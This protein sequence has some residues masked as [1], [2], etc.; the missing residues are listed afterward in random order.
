MKS[1]LIFRGLMIL[2]V[3]VSGASIHNA[4][5]RNLLENPNADQELKRWRAFGDFGGG[6]RQP[7]TVEVGAVKRANMAQEVV[8]VGNLIG[9]ATV[10]VSTGNNS[11]FVVRNGGYFFQ[12][13][14]LT[15][16]AVGQYAVLIGRGASERINDNGAITGLPY[17]YGYMMEEKGDSVLAYLQG[18]QM[19]ANTRMRDEWVDMW[20]IFRVPEKTKRIRF[21]L[22]QALRNGVPQNGSAARFDNLGLYLFAVKEDAEAFGEMDG[23]GFSG[24][25]PTGG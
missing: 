22:N 12:D 7:M 9:E 24:R 14:L 20:G 11:C 10:E 1:S 23:A 18:Q 4:Q 21:F 5:Y 2:S 19:L 15:D 6:P 25:A 13:V 3:F 17:L 8:V 16:D